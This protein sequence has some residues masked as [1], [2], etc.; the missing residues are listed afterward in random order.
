MPHR[1]GKGPDQRRVEEAL[2]RRPKK[3]PLRFCTS[4]PQVNG[5]TI[6]GIRW[7]TCLWRTH[8]IPLVKKWDSTLL[9]FAKIAD[10]DG[11][12]NLNASPRVQAETPPGIK[13]ISSSKGRSPKE[14]TKRR[15][16]FNYGLGKA[17][18]PA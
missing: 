11:M 12:K 8:P 18:C 14:S 1:K 15:E 9:F 3:L 16:P 13:S 7:I 10:S 2:P 5:G 6:A 17:F 4:P